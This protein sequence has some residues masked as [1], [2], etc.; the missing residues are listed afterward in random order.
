LSKG[1][2]LITKVPIVFE[3]HE[4]PD[5]NHRAFLPIII[6]DYRPDSENDDDYHL[7]VL[8]LMRDRPCGFLVTDR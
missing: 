4:N 7:Q 2:R 5:Y 3:S 1:E 8:Y 6:Q